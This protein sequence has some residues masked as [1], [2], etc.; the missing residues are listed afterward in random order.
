MAVIM[1]NDGPRINKNLLDKFGMIS[2]LKNNF[3]PIGSVFKIDSIGLH[4]RFIKKYN[5]S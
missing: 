4:Q 1:A 2:S 5:E 3:K